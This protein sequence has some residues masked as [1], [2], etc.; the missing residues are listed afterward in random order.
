LY[1]NIINLRQYKR[2]AL[3]PFIA[4]FL[5]MKK[6]L[7]FLVL[8]V[9]GVYLYHHRDIFRSNDT[10]KFTHTPELLQKRAK[11]YAFTN[12]PATVEFKNGNLYDGNGTPAL[13]VT[14]GIKSYAFPKRYR[15]ADFYILIDENYFH[16]SLIIDKKDTNAA[17][18]IEL[19][20]SQVG[21]N[22]YVSGKTT[23]AND[24]SLSFRTHPMTSLG[25]GIKVTYFRNNGQTK[26]E[27]F[28]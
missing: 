22:Y 20:L 5:K 23:S 11:V 28:D 25:K 1:L 19:S 27:W 2:C 24:G 26:T 18:D 3:C 21:N 9:T 16:N 6:I 15:H 17:Y 8:A 12:N 4:Q 7:L 10:I 14:D 13:L